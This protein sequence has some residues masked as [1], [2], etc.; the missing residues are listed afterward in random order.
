MIF[1][2][3]NIFCQSP[4]FCPLTCHFSKQLKSFIIY[5]GCCLFFVFFQICSITL[6][7]AFCHW[8]P[9]IG[10]WKE[11]FLCPELILC[12]LCYSS[13][14]YL[15]VL[16]WIF[17]LF[18]ILHHCEGVKTLCQ[19]TLTKVIQKIQF[20]LNACYYKANFS[21]LCQ[22]LILGLPSYL[23]ALSCFYPNSNWVSYKELS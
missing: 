6:A 5:W 19:S 13:L 8:L 7:S 11:G 21:W 1:A 20:A 17:H 18:W 3:A 16:F 22:S 10:C 4:Q 9:F 2:L 12:S 14:G 15:P 23:K